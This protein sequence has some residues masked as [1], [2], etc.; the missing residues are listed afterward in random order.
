[1]DAMSIDDFPNFRYHPDPVA[2]GNV[3]PSSAACR[4]C[5]QARG[6]VYLRDAI[7]AGREDYSEQICPW[8]IADG[9]AASALDVAFAC[10]LDI[11]ESVSETALEE[12]SLRTPGYVSFQ[13][14]KWLAHCSD[15]CRF[16]GDASVEQVSQASAATI[17]AWC[18]ANGTDEAV[19]L[20]LA[21]DYVP[22]ADIGFYTFECLHC[23][24]IQFHVDAA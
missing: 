10:S 9:R 24:L 20:E 3:G 18:A 22:G 1:M 7:H 13:E 17:A 8:C 16:L 21:S 14:E 12:L 19:W 6:Y 11:D 23:G 15:I 4:V 2:T 5:Q